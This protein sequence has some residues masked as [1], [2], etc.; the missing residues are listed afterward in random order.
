MPIAELFHTR[1]HPAQAQLLSG[2]SEH[3]G[4]ELPNGVTVGAIQQAEHRRGLRWLRPK[5][6]GCG[7]Q[8][9]GRA[10]RRHKGCAEPACPHVPC[11]PNLEAAGRNPLPPSIL[12]QP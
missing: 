12:D 4:P 7:Q 8:E 2:A 1:P 3:Q 6:S 9:H 10:G 11:G 5:D